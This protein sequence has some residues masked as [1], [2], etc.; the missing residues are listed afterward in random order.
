MSRHIKTS[1]SLYEILGVQQKSSKKDIKAKWIRH[2]L[3]LHPDSGHPKACPDQFR[4]VNEAYEI[5]KCK[6]KRAEYDKKLNG[7]R[8][9]SNN[10]VK[11][12]KATTKAQQSS[13]AGF[14]EY[15]E[16]NYVYNDANEWNRAHYGNETQ[17]KSMYTRNREQNDHKIFGD[18]KVQDLTKHQRYFF[19][20]TLKDRQRAAAFEK[21]KNSKS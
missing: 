21:K 20:K 18:T 6:I 17:Q 5:L 7:I 11:Y 1:K 4:I 19:N 9:R 14:G 15:E 3:I 2:M 13:S 10:S 8:P 16:F 12:Y